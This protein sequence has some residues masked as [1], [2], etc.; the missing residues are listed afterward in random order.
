MCKFLYTWLNYIKHIHLIAKKGKAKKNG[1]LHIFE[2]VYQKLIL[3][4][5]PLYNIFAGSFKTLYKVSDFTII[6]SLRNNQKYVLF[7]K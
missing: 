1:F 2:S 5:K 6:N 7:T 4:W 3:M